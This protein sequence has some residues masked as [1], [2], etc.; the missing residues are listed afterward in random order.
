MVYLYPARVNHWR[1]KCKYLT[2]VTNSIAY[3]NERGMSEESVAKV[4]L[5]L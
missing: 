2:D 5:G 4:W 3:T 1:S